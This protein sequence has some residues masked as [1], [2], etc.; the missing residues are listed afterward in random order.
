MTLINTL[1]N[2]SALEIVA[3][4]CTADAQ[5]FNQKTQGTVLTDFILGHGVPVPHPPTL[6]LPSVVSAIVGTVNRDDSTVQG[7]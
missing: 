2:G 5:R 3:D 7:Q 6:S 4:T 1:A